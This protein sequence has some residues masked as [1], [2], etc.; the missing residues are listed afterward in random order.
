MYVCVSVYVCIY[1][2][3]YVCVC[4]RVRARACMYVCKVISQGNTY[5]RFDCRSPY[6]TKILYI[7]NNPYECQY[8][9]YSMYQTL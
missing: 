5:Q 9:S 4:V 2:C 7:L 8:A 1:V 3:V 6:R